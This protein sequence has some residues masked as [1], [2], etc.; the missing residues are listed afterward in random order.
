M[1]PINF[2]TLT[3]SS[4]A[5]HSRRVFLFWL[6]FTKQGVLQ[7]GLEVHLAQLSGRSEVSKRRN[8]GTWLE[9]YWVIMIP[10]H[11]LVSIVV[12]IRAATGSRIRRRVFPAS[13]EESNIIDNDFDFASH[14]AILFPSVLMELA[15]DSDVLTLHEILV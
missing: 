1:N 3:F 5:F 7:V 13:R 6:F 12:I 14:L 9:R 11:A 15:T 10:Y 8:G 2:P 4:P